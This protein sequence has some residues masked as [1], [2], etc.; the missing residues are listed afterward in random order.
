MSSLGDWNAALGYYQQEARIF[1][2]LLV[3][4]PAN[5]LPS[6]T[7]RSPTRRSARSSN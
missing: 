5:A 2:A 1:E 6:A 4:E 7:P 3:L